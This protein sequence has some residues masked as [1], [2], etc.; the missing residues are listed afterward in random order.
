MGGERRRKEEGEGKEGGDL[1]IVTSGRLA[2]EG[3]GSV[4]SAERG[5]RGEIVVLPERGKAWRQ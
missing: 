4:L 5:G 3:F 1:Y 2:R